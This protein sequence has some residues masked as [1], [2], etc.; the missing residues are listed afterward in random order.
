MHVSMGGLEEAG[1]PLV[2]IQLDKDVYRG[3][4]ADGKVKLSRV[5]EVRLGGKAMRPFVGVAFGRGVAA[6]GDRGA[7]RVFDREGKLAFDSSSLP[8]P[9]KKSNAALVK[10]VVAAIA[11][12]AMVDYAKEQAKADIANAEY[13]RAHRAKG[14]RILSI[15]FAAIVVSCALIA[16]VAFLASRE[17]RM[18]LVTV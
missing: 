9:P 10:E 17:S 15:T 1:S 12:D 7:F 16:V 14:M 5:R 8:K 13:E 3:D 4:V 18:M 6:I 2:W 11:A